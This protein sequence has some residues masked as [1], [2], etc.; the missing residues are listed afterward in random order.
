MEAGCQGCAGGAMS[1]SPT[2]SF[3]PVNVPQRDPLQ[4]NDPWGTWNQNQA[5]VPVHG[6]QQRTQAHAQA[7]LHAQMQAQ[8]H[9]QMGRQCGVPSITAQ[10]TLFPPS[11]SGN[12]SAVG[13]PVVNDLVSHAWERIDAWERSREFQ[14]DF[15]RE[16]LQRCQR[17]GK[18]RSWEE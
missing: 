13:N 3:G 1:M 16:R 5:N 11:P 14:R 15:S 6:Q 12:V 2:G 7:Q 8:M 17:F 10:Q 4:V 18:E 9:A